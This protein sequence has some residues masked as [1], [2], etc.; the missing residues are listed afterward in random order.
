MR[1]DEIVGRHRGLR[2]RLLGPGGVEQNAPLR[3]AI[4]IVDVDL[5][6]ETVELGFRQRIGPFLLERV[7]G[8]EH[9]EGSRQIVA[10][11]RKRHVLLLHRLEQRRL[12]ARARTVDLVRHQ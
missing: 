1:R 7:L 10:G 5:H 12:R 8:R 4:R 6:Q 3:L 2:P 11:A 9:V